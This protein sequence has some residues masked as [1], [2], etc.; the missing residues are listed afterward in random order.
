MRKLDANLYKSMQDFAALFEKATPK[1]NPER[2]EKIL[3]IDNQ[4]G[5][6]IA[7]KESCLN[8]AFFI[9]DFWNKVFLRF[10]SLYLSENI[11]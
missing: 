2:R 9:P 5:R 4:T 3:I 8:D 6:I 1:T 10:N 11:K 7:E